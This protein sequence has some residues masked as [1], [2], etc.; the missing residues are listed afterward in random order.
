MKK[1]HNYKPEFLISIHLQISLANGVLMMFFRRACGGKDNKIVLRKVTEVK[2][3]LVK[4]YILGS[5]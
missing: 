1:C 2:L 4:N 3:K 5:L